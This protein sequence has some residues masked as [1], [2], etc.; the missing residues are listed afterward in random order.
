MKNQ[1]NDFRQPW[2]KGYILYD[3]Y[4]YSFEYRFVVTLIEGNIHNQLYSRSRW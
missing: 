4:K 3:F 2:A 1:Q